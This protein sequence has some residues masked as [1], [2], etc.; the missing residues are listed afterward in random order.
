MV[1]CCANPYRALEAN[2][3]DKDFELFCK[4]T[5][6]AYAEKEGLHEFSIQHNQHLKA[7]DGTYQIDV[8]AEFTALGVKNKVLIE[9]KKYNK[10]V[11]RKVVAELEEKLR[12]VGAN[13]G[14]VM[15]TSG[16]QSGAVQFAE[17][18]GIALLQIVDRMVKHITN[19]AGSIADYQMIS[20][21]MNRYLPKYFVVKWDCAYDYPYEEVYPTPKMYKTAKEK[22]K[23]ALDAYWAK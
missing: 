2:I 18:H 4:N 7:Y 10:P 17:A 21:L 8:L 11:E 5:L 6:E 19:S 23:N 13:K 14:I 16:F 15:S 9:C 22:V 12:S 1:E 3:S 20:S